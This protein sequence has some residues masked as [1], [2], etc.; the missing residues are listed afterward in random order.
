MFLE[1]FLRNNRNILPG[2][3][4]NIINNFCHIHSTHWFQDVGGKYAIVIEIHFHLEN[5][6]V[7]ALKWRFQST[8]Y[9]PEY[10]IEINKHKAN[11]IVNEI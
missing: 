3:S 5:T 11:Y 2:E 9:K 4:R 7:A 10:N 1:P 8:K 6:H